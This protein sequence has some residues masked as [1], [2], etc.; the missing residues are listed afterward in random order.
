METDGNWIRKRPLESV[1]IRSLINFDAGVAVFTLAATLALAWL[2]WFPFF[3]KKKSKSTPKPEPFLSMTSFFLCVEGAIRRRHRG[4]PR[5]A[6]FLLS[7]FP[8]HLLF[9]DF[10]S[11]RPTIP[12]RR[13][14]QPTDIVYLPSCYRVF[15]GCYRVLPGFTGFYW[16][17]LRFSGF[18]LVLL[19]FT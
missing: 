16:V 18:Y 7:P 11:K 9:C 2:C 14:R 10:Y 15:T 4:P 3:V 5:D 12:V 17:L 1:V 8:F 6:P 13:T 19:G